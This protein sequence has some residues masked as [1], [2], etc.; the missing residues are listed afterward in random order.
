MQRALAD[1]AQSVERILGKDEVASSN[2]AISSKKRRHP[3]GCLLFLF[4]IARFEIKMQQSGGLL[5]QPVQKLVATIICVKGANAPNLAI[6]SQKER[7]SF[8]D[9]SFLM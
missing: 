9:L 6:S 3:I 8:D 7:S 2:L 1:I 4:A 5:R